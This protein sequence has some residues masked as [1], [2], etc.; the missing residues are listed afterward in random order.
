MSSYQ[1]IKFS[2][3]IQQ[4]LICNDHYKNVGYFIT[5]IHKFPYPRDKEWLKLWASSWI[6]NSLLELKLK[7]KSKRVLHSFERIKGK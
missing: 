3:L 2:T 7:N 1:G 6:P 4:C 5:L